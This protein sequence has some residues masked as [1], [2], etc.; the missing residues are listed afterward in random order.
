M[1]RPLCDHPE[2]EVCKWCD[3]I[4]LLPQKSRYPGGVRWAVVDRLSKEPHVVGMENENQARMFYKS[5]TE[6]ASTTAY[7]NNPERW[8]QLVAA[9]IHWVVQTDLQVK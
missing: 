1:T 8:P 6:F 4:P 5:W 7:P 3:D 9:R 2:G